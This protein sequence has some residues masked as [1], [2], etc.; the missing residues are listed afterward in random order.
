[1]SEAYTLRDI[2]WILIA[3]ALVLMMQGGFILL[4][5]GFVRAKNSINVAIKNLVDFCLSASVFWIFGF[6]LM[7]GAS[8]GGLF[9]SSGFFFGA[10][11]ADPF[12]M[13]FFIFQLVFC[14]TATT[15]ISGAVAE[16]MRFSGYLLVAFVVAS[17]IYPILGHWVWGGLESGTATGWLAQMGFIDFAGSTVVHSVGGWVALAAVLIVGPR[18]GR[19]DEKV[20]IQG[21]S[22]PMATLGALL[23]WFGWFGFNGGSTLGVT[24]DI[25]FIIANTT[26]SGAFGGLIALAT[27]YYIFRTFD[28]GYVINGALAGLVGITASAHV[29]SQFG[30]VFIGL[31]A[32]LL[33]VIA[34]LVLQ[35]YRIDDAIGAFPV[36]AV[37][38]VWGTLAVALLGDAN[39]WGTGLTRGQQF[40]VQLTGVGVTFVWAFG[41]GFALLWVVNRVWPLRVSEE[42]ER[43]GLNV[44]EHDAHTALLDLLNAMEAQRLAADVSGRVTVEPHTEV[45]QIADQYNRVLDSVS[46]LVVTQDERDRLQLSIIKLL[47]EITDVADGDLTVEAEVTEDAMG[48]VADSFNFMIS[49]LRDVIHRVLRTTLSVNLSANQIRSTAQHLAQGSESQAAQIVD[50]TA[51]VDEMS[52]SIQQVSGNATQSAGV[53]SQALVTAQAGTK[54]VQNTISGMQRIRQ[55]GQETSKRIKRLGESSQEIG[56]IVQLIRSIAKRTSLLALNASLEAAAAGEAGRGFAVVAADVKRLSE[57]SS[58]AADQITDL[59]ESIQTETNGAVAAMELTTREVVEGSKLANEAG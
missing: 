4:E 2:M 3:A 30:A 45:G 41:V 38:G 24:E 6:A 12:Q 58:M 43:L 52:V 17:V 26:L 22:L 47:E 29:M 51:A 35:R 15:I 21:H 32:G 27:S 1:M 16:R 46:E 50:T 23:L 8:V 48:A 28:V 37:A 31:V 18:I 56:E 13:S 10:T 7:F 19:F 44:A 5:S 55:Q 49:Q 57:R 36:H 9:G 53:A 42:D 59:V 14:G 20:E 33:S 40:L 34:T 54:A 25:P 11:G 39:A